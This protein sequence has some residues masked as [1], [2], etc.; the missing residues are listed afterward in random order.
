VENAMSAVRAARLARNRAERIATRERERAAAQEVIRVAAR[1]RQ[2]ARRKPRPSVALPNP[3]DLNHERFIDVFGTDE[4]P[5]L[6]GL[7][8]RQRLKL[9]APGGL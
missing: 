7:Q 8:L 1:R 4:Q 3:A 6:R 9:R 5:T 2:N